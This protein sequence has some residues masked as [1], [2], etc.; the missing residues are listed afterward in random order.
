MN[1]IHLVVWTI[2]LA[3]S[4]SFQQTAAP[5]SDEA[6]R[7]SDIYAI[8]SKMIRST[9][10]L[11]LI[12]ATTLTERGGYGS[13]FRPQSASAALSCIQ[14]PQEDVASFDEV[15]KDY[16]LRKDIAA[17]LANEFT[18]D[19]PYQVLTSGAAR[20]FLED[21]LRST[22]Q[23]VPPGGIPPNPNP[24]FPKARQVFSLSDVFFNKSRTMALIYI[25]EMTTT[26]DGGGSWRI[27][28]R[29]E[30]GQ[31][32][33]VTSGRPAPGQPIWRTCG[34]AVGH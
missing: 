3:T 6:A 4:T 7:R 22:P 23:V 14:P 26:S 34:W 9:D 18:L 29:A 31:W 33:E 10:E 11:I 25:S 16:E 28:K 13:P 1:T 12:E 27:F 32:N 17:T 24:L 5:S 8:Y 30:A 20:T 21:G 15:L 2:T 19:R